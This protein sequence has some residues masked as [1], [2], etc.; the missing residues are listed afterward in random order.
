MS[1]DRL[2]H[3]VVKF[4]SKLF[5]FSRIGITVSEARVHF[6]DKNGFL[7]AVRIFGKNLLHAGVVHNLRRVVCIRFFVKFGQ[8]LVLGIL[9][10][11]Y[12]IMQRSLELAYRRLVLKLPLVKS[13]VDHPPGFV[14][15]NGLRTKHGSFKI[16]VEFGERLGTGANRMNLHWIQIRNWLSSPGMR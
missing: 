2:H 13:M 7:L 14:V 11:C 4:F 1:V 12:C 6:Q 8:T 5:E 9:H 15:G 10:S 16:R 3:S